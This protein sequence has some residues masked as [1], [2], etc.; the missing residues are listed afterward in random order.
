[1]IKQFPNCTDESSDG[2][3]G[4]YEDVGPSNVLGRDVGDD[5]SDDSDG[6]DDGD[7]EEDSKEESDGDKTQEKGVVYKGQIELES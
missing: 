2:G 4:R 6:S 5:N 7:D 1:M 3:F